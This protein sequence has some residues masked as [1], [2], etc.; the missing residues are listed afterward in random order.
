MEIQTFKTSLLCTGVIVLVMANAVVAQDSLF[1][2]S[3]YLLG[4]A[5]T[6]NAY[7]TSTDT[8][9]GQVQANG[10]ETRSVVAPFTWNWGD[11]NSTSGF[12]P[13]SHTYA[14]K[15]H[16]YVLAVTAH[17]SGGVK[18]TVYALVRFVPANYDAS[19][20]PADVQVT[21]PESMPTLGSRLG[22]VNPALSV[23]DNSFFTLTPR[24]ALESFLTAASGVEMDFTNGDVYR[25][26]GLFQQV[27][28]RDS[29]AGGAYSLWFSDP[30]AF[31]AGDGFVA[32][33]I[34]YSSLTHEM[35]HN[36]TLNTPSSYYTGNGIGGNANAIHSETMA[37]IYQHAA[38]YVL[39]NS[40]VELGLPDDMKF[41]VTASLYSSVK[42]LRKF[43]DE[44]LATGKEFA[45]WNGPPA[46]PNASLRTFMTLAYK[47]CE[48][49]ETSGMGY[50]APVKRMV[51]LIQL[52]NPQI[53]SRFD[54]LNN[55]P[56]ADTFRSTFIVSGICYGFNS[57]L[58]QEFRDLNFPV[59]D[60]L[61]DSLW[62]MAGSVNT[63]PVLTHL[64]SNV[65]LDS[66]G[67]SLEVDL[68]SPVL[69]TDPDGDALDYSATS[70]NPSVATVGISGSLLTVNAQS[71]GHAKI[72]VTASDLQGGEEKKTAFLV[73]YR[74]DC[75]FDGV[76]EDGDV[77]GIA[78]DSPCVGGDTTN[79]DDNCPGVSNATQADVDA[80]GHG[81][82]C[83]NCPKVSNAN[84]LITI[85]MTG[86][87]NLSGTYTSSDVIL[88]VNYVFKGGAAPLPCPANGD[89]NCSGNVTSADI[90]T[91]VN[92][93]FKG[94]AAP[95]NVCTA[96]GLSWSCP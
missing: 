74:P 29:T 59:S 27:M 84:E 56:A 5:S 94:G 85:A 77:S 52:W 62:T 35:G 21:V 92:H 8:G 49:A 15:T 7:I 24:S 2:F 51:H 54:H 10:V 89:A 86:D 28:L 63:V 20:Y 26:Q 31:G 39:I 48:H 75:D 22:P 13:Q 79:C 53:E 73:D 42:T 43:F 6:L 32:G 34:G 23:F 12:F 60:G 78:G 90:I 72:T 68:E 36:Y 33:S 82:V 58:R 67:Q 16:Q 93:V 76:A 47:F 18:D 1:N 95:C 17:Y 91:L 40:A 4:P 41:E 50:R 70:S 69:F 19:G 44:Y 3:R 71:L 81:D 55:T 88:I 87:V 9:T 25:Y 46:S 65:L 83:D 14:D 37:Q 96:A 80:D 61:Y 30:V 38:G 64:I 45:S 66:C 57:D 11:G